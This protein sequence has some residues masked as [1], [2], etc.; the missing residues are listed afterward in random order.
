[1]AKPRTRIPHARRPAFGG[2]RR[3][4]HYTETMRCVEAERDQMISFIS[5]VSGERK[6][7]EQ[8]VSEIASSASSL[9]VSFD[10]A[11][12]FKWRY[13]RNFNEAC[14]QAAT[15]LPKQPST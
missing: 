10:E 13:W 12:F 2:Y 4:P 8:I 1:M 6:S 3:I 9:C 15:L 5:S 14:K 11:L 7:V